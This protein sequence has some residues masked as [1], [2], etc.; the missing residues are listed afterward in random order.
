MDRV[1]LVN[2]PIGIHPFLF[3]EMRSHYD[4]GA[5]LELAEAPVAPGTV[6]LLHCAIVADRNSPVPLHFPAPTDIHPK[7]L[8]MF[9]STPRSNIH[10]SFSIRASWILVYNPF[11][12]PLPL[13][14]SFPTAPRTPEGRAA[15]GRGQGW[16]CLNSAFFLFWWRAHYLTCLSTN[17]LISKLGTQLCLLPW[18]R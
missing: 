10:L 3:S 18:L 14:P 6:A 11:P 1:S 16:A 13:L 9:L 2:S 17:I 7:A 4:A 8:H 5:S 15:G 12:L